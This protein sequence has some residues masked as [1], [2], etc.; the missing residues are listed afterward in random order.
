M[1]LSE[2]IVIVIDSAQ[3][4]F[5]TP[6][7]FESDKKMSCFQMFKRITEI[8]VCNKNF[9]N[10]KHE[11]ALMVL[12]PSDVQWKCD[13]TSDVDSFRKKLDTVQD[14][15]V[16]NSQKYFP[17]QNAF[18]LV[19]QRLTRSKLLTHDNIVRLI[20]LYSRSENFPKFN[21]ADT[22]IEELAEG[23]N[24]FIDLIYVHEPSC[25]EHKCKEIFIELNKMKM[26]KTSYILEVA[27]DA[28]ELH[29]FMARLLAHPIQRVN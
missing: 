16:E 25:S 12:T 7:E 20:F 29:R 6:F 23:T 4:S 9:I 5:S 24:F 21:L 1:N 27:R 8:F 10:K 15:L 3:E 2:K 26:H 14:T 19:H 22:I 17:L 18:E 28:M 11:F 13:F